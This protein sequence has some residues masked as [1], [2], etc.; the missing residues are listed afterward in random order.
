VGD[1]DHGEEGDELLEAIDFLVGQGYGRE[2]LLA[3]CSALEIAAYYRVA[4]KRHGQNLV[5]LANLVAL[6]THVGFTGKRDALQ[7]LARALETEHDGT[8]AGLRRG[9]RELVASGQVQVVKGGAHRRRAG[10]RARG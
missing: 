9:L 6:G 7:S 8:P 10:G 5:T 4:S 3:R 2:D 1:G